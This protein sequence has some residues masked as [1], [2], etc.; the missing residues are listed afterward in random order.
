MI[1][2]V[3][4]RK[5]SRDTNAR[6]ALLKNLANDL[7]LRERVRTTE[8]KAKAIRPFVEKL[9]TKSKDN[10]ITS[11]RLLISKLGRENSVQK[12]LEL[13]GPTFKDRPGGYTRIIKLVPRVGDKAEMAMIEFS[14]N[15]SE[16]A[17]ILKL[18]KKPKTKAAKTAKGEKETKT[19]KV[20][21]T[22][23]GK[24]AKNTK[25]QKQTKTKAKETNTKTAK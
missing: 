15:V 20:K 1:H 3:S 22:R 13:V 17:A 2:R 25:T 19:N 12:L 9:I 4:H 14:E 23:T 18:A 5:F 24:L 21:P 7:I 10:T 6:K 8:A 16:K 11:R